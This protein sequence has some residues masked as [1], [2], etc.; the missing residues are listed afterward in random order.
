MKKW[1]FLTSSFALVF[2]FCGCATMNED[3]M[4]GSVQ[5]SV[6]SPTLAQSSPDEPS[7][8][9][10]KVAIARFTNETR[11]GQSF[12]LDKDNDRI[13]KAAVDVLSKKLLDT[14]KFL[15]IERADLDKVQ[16]EINIASLPAY[17]N[18]AD[19][20]IL[21]SITEYGYKDTSDTGIFSR[22]KTQTAYAKGKDFSL[23][24]RAY[25]SD[26]AVLDGSWTSLPANT[27][28]L[29]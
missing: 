28:Q 13:G 15:L 3:K 29:K 19:Y 24:I 20:I 21:G 26:K 5:V 17:K 12:F 1:I 23:Y 14:D 22:V 4:V 2:F 6:V 11:T 27:I 7:G 18:A 9:K 16:K 25:W 8:V 10:R